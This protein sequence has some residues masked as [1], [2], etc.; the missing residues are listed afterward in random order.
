MNLLDAI[1]GRRSI[2]K[3][4]NKSISDD[5]IR[6]ILALATHAPSSMNGQPWRF[7]VVRDK[8]TKRRLVEIKNRYCPT[9]KK[10]F[11]ADFLSDAPVV[12]VV[13]VDIIKSYNRDI[14]NAVLASANILLGA[15]SY[16]IGSV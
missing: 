5:I 9:E 11:R 1:K 3:Y 10:M 12:V 8:E 2:R 6:H 4:Q 13:C 14:E 16:N 15:Y 7:V